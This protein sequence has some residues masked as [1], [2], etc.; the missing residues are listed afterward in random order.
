MPNHLSTGQGQADL[1]TRDLVI[2]G[3]GMIGTSVG[4]GAQ[5]AGADTVILEAGDSAFHAARGNFGLVWAQSK[6][7][8]APEYGIW[9]RDAVRAWPGFEEELLA[10]TGIH[11]HYRRGAGL[12]LCLSESE[13]EKRTK[14]IA[15]VAAHGIEGHAPRMIDAQTLREMVPGVGPEVVGGSVSDMDG[16]CHSLALYRAQIAAYDGAGG[17]IVSGRP[18]TAI[19]PVAQGYRVETA[20]HAVTAPRVLIAAGLGVDALAAPFGLPPMSM[21]QKGEILVTERA[22]PFLPYVLSSLRQTPEGT[23]LIGDTK[24]DTG[25]DDRSSHHGITELARR[26][27]QMFPAIAGLRVVRSW[28]CL[29]VL[30]RDGDPVYDQSP[31]H[32]GIFVATTHSAVTLAPMHRG[33]LA[34]WILGGARPQL[35]DAF[36]AARLGPAH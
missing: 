12:Q 34:A 33:P 2:I 10:R 25:L 19:T 1:G 3:G 11:T 20:T 32:P 28:A 36:A 29:R 27:V 15:K 5:A 14:L 26:A 8:L 30:T 18:V 21:P 31:S 23:V 7:V 4:L 16:D 24:E 17:R 9:T 6:G 13:F 22:Q 35:F